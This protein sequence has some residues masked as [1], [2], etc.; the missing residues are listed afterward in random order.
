MSMVSADRHC[1]L[2]ALNKVNALYILYGY[3]LRRFMS[4]CVAALA[5]FSSTHEV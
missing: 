3:L 4:V 5:V 2:V 1:E